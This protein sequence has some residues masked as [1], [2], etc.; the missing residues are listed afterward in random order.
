[1]MSVD[2]LIGSTGFVGTNLSRAHTFTQL[3]NRENI[4]LSADDTFKNVICAAAPGSM[5]EANR[6][7]Y[8]DSKLISNLIK[9][10]SAISTETFILIS[11]VA[12]LNNFG[13][14]EDESSNDYQY[15]AGYGGNRRVLEAFCQ[16]H[17]KRCLVV[18]LPALIGTGLKKNFIFDLLNPMPSMLKRTTLQYLLDQAPGSLKDI[19]DTLYT[20]D[21]EIE[22]YRIDRCALSNHENKQ[23]I[24]EFI[25]KSG[26]A[27]ETFTNPESTFQ[28]YDLSRL[29]AD[30]QVAL[31]SELNVV[32]LATEP[33]RAKDIYLSLTGR[34]MQE[35][36]AEVHCE[37]LI[38][39]FGSQFN[40]N[41]NYIEPAD[42]V[43]QRLSHFYTE[44]KSNV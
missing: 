39:S 21:T 6:L 3:F 37:N 40:A 1:M 44:Q 4:T 41:G 9:S 36:L 38:T 10:I 32:H 22:M 17:F 31:N 2:A 11:T 7:P 27:A 19:I 29:Y 8:H 12:T 13:D 28:Y 42:K 18:R 30:I 20:W 24:D 33:L 14:G 15:Q 5:F 26:F 23:C 25:T 34:P 43:M 35:N 16:N